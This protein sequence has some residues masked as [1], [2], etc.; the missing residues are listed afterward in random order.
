MLVCGSAFGPYFAPNQTFLLEGTTSELLIFNEYSVTSSLY[1]I[2]DTILEITVPY[3]NE[4]IYDIWISEEEPKDI[5]KVL[6]IIYQNLIMKFE[7]FL[8]LIKN[9]IIIYRYQQH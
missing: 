2:F 9:N 6:K 5:C 1:Q 4:A 3:K 8:K 7:K